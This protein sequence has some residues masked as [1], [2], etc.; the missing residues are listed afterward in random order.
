MFTGPWD[1]TSCLAQM[2]QLQHP[3]VYNFSGASTWMPGCL[4]SGEHSLQRGIIKPPAKLS[5]KHQQLWE[6]QASTSHTQICLLCDLKKM[7]K[8]ILAVN[9]E[10]STEEFDR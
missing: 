8:F 10:C 7:N 3:Y 2:H 4:V 9:G 1:P 5:Q 6:A